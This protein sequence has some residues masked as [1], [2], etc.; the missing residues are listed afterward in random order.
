MDIGAR[1]RDSLA[2]PILFLQKL[3][4]TFKPYFQFRLF[5]YDI[6]LCLSR[7]ETPPFR[8]FSLSLSSLEPQFSLSQGLLS[9]DF[10]A[11]SRVFVSLARIHSPA[12]GS[13]GGKKKQGS[14]CAMEYGGG[15]KRFRPEAALNGNG[16]FKKSKPGMPSHCSSTYTRKHIFLL[17]YYVQTI[18]IVLPLFLC[19]QSQGFF[20]RFVLL[21]W[22]CLIWIASECG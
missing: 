16:G 11:L 14:R 20:C 2:A 8:F 5:I 12:R 13:L 22:L 6:S 19:A 10:L 18:E 4:T 21:L 1:S 3:S 7:I 15:R 17:L 9:S